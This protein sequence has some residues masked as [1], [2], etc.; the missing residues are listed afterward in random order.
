MAIKIL[1]SG[2]TTSEVFYPNGKFTVQMT[3]LTGTVQDWFIQQLPKELADSSTEWTEVTS[4]PFANSAGRRSITFDGSEGFKYR[5]K[6]TSASATNSG[7]EAY[8]YGART[9]IF[10]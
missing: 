4:A 7:I 9:T 10:R 6:N 8:W 5:I 2:Q 3:G 1:T